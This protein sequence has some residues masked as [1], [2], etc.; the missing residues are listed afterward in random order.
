MLCVDT[1]VWPWVL[2]GGQSPSQGRVWCLW[3]APAGG[4]P[5]SCPVFGWHLRDSCQAGL[6]ASTISLQGSLLC[7]HPAWARVVRGHMPLVLC[8]TCRGQWL[9]EESVLLRTSWGRPARVYTEGATLE[10]WDPQIRSDGPGWPQVG[11]QGSMFCS[12]SGAPRAEQEPQECCAGWLLARRGWGFLGQYS[13][14]GQ[15]CDLGV[16]RPQA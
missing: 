12:Q 3:G 6:L 7:P 10:V 16:S 15:R 13:G 4:G 14:R 2:R 9:W 1:R 8:I 11:W 5:R